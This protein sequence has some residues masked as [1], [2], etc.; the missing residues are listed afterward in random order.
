MSAVTAR[1][2]EC[3]TG[4]DTLKGKDAFE[5][6]FR[7]SWLKSALATRVSHAVPVFCWLSL[8]SQ[9]ATRT[10]AYRESLAGSRGRST[11]QLSDNFRE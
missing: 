5:S 8:P 3:V 1:L 11:V 4:N 2:D 7:E 6:V 10:A 9:A